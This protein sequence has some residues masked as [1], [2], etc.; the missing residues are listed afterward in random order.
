MLSKTVLT[1]LVILSLSFSIH[2]VSPSYDDVKENDTIFL[3]EIGPGQTVSILVDHLV[4]EG[5]IYG[6]GGTYDMAIAED[7]PEGWTFRE[8][9]LYQKPLQVIITADPNATEGVYY[10]K[11]KVIDEDDG[12]ELGN[13]TFNVKIRV[14]MDVADFGVSPSHIN[15]G[16]G[17]PARFE[18]TITNKAS[19]SDV[20]Q[21]SATGTKKWEFIR[22][23]F[24]PAK[25][26]KTIYYEIVGNEEEDYR[27]RI[28]MVSLA[29][30]KI[31]AEENVTV[32]VKSNLIWDYKATNNGV[33]LFP[34]FEVPIYAFAGLV[35]NLFPG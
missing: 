16:P 26:S 3:G 27:A 18:I 31:N 29:S 10:A 20:F 7:L 23:V 35:S 24:V 21:V 19:T 22:P 11:V 5:G 12:E 6:I 4:T 8:S 30:D 1:F 25:S 14:V 2:L 28:R 13:V 15:T 33:V 9:E 34:I 32:S 17:Q